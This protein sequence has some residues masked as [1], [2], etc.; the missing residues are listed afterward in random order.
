MEIDRDDLAQLPDELPQAL[1]V[2]ANRRV[3]VPPRLRA[4]SLP[5]KVER[6]TTH[7]WGTEASRALATWDR[8]RRPSRRS[9]GQRDSFH[10]T[11]IPDHRRLLDPSGMLCRQHER[12]YS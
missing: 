9:A 12:F 6:R 1:A 11:S 2:F 8:S 10:R 3:P 5:A 7:A 4:K